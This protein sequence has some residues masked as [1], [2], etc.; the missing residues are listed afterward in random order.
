MATASIVFRLT[1]E[2]EYWS[3]VL[4]TVSGQ[5]ADACHPD[6]R[7]VPELIKDEDLDTWE[8]APGHRYKCTYKVHSYR[9]YEGDYDVDTE[10]D[11]VE[12]LGPLETAH[13]SVVP[14]QGT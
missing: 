2:D 3:L 12:D 13:E 9:T 4:E 8:L 5:P 10:I 7:W 6:D 1:M 14:T 11:D